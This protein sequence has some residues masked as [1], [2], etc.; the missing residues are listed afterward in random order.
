MKQITISVPRQYATTLADHLVD[1]GIDVT[2]VIIRTDRP[3]T[4]HIAYPSDF[5]QLQHILETL[6]HNKPRRP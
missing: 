6:T 1:R 4:I 2:E 5:A 3:S